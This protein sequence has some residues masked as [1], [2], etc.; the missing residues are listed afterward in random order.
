MTSLIMP[1]I[2]DLIDQMV[3]TI[4]IKNGERVK[5]R[6]IIEED[7]ANERSLRRSEDENYRFAHFF[8]NLLRRGGREMRKDYEDEFKEEFRLNLVPDILISDFDFTNRENRPTSRKSNEIL[9]ELRVQCKSLTKK[10]FEK[11]TG[12][13][14]TPSG[15][16]RYS[17]GTGSA[18]WVLLGAKQV[19]FKPKP[20]GNFQKYLDEASKQYD[21]GFE[22]DEMLKV[23][24]IGPKVRDLALSTFN[25]QYFPVDV[26][27]KGVLFRTGLIC[28]AYKLKVR[29]SRYRLSDDY[30]DIR[31]LGCGLAKEAKM[32]P[33]EF[34][35]TLWNFAEKFC[36][37][38]YKKNC[39]ACPV[40]LCLTH[41]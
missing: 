3:E 30:W 34:D 23:H 10:D 36:N 1:K 28:Y 20:Y 15:E 32:T 27:V 35:R 37:K 18:A 39:E 29:I 12:I 16:S 19:I 41:L 31:K 40:T 4:T 21:D 25:E 13:L 6:T 7:I 14:S 26:N 5:L 22:N 38:T 17:F 2:S 24:F 33:M 8:C 9:D 11:L